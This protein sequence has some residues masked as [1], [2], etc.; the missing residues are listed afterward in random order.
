[1]RKN[2]ELWLAILSML[3]IGGVYF[4]VTVWYQEVPA[5]SGFFG[6]LLGVLGFILMLMTELLYSLRKRSRTARWGRM[7][8]WLEFHIYTGLV[9]PFMVLLHSSWK[10]QGLAGAVMLMTVVIVLSGF[11]GR[12]IY[13]A[14]PRTD[15]AEVQAAVL[16]Q[17]MAEVDA[18]VK[19]MEGM[20]ET[21]KLEAKEVNER[22]E[23]LKKEQERLRQQVGSLTSARRMLAIWH[24]VHIPLGMALFT[25]AFIHIGAAIYYATLLH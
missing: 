7:S 12:Y 17:M 6:H 23:G 1:M 11:V 15:G 19:R 18:E 25:A 4:L 8:D 16:E 13:T 14:V 24:T 21:G 10:F 20:Q 22:V 3:L 9:G 2:K 5:S